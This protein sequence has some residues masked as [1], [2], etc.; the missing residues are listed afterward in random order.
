MKKEAEVILPA[1]ISREL[2]SHSNYFGH[3]GDVLVATVADER[4]E[5]HLVPGI[6]TIDP[7]AT[8]Y[9]VHPESVQISYH[10]AKLAGGSR[11]KILIVE[12]ISPICQNGQR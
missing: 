4:F 12:Q 9:L 2:V 1:A 10:S 8:D 7:E 3:G 6:T 5:I 11:C